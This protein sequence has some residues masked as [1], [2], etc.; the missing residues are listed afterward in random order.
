MV[1]RNIHSIE[2][3]LKKKLF[4]FLIDTY[5]FIRFLIKITTITPKKFPN[6]SD[7]SKL[8]SGIRI[9]KISRAIDS[10]IR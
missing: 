3:K 2:E 9:C 5:S 10:V 7:H 8:L 6:K 4:Y 1:L